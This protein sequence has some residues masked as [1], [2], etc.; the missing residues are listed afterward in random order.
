MASVFLLDN[1]EIRVRHA[2]YMNARI[3]LKHPA[4]VSAAYRCRDRNRLFHRLNE[5][6]WRAGY[7]LLAERVQNGP[8]VCSGR[9][10]AAHGLKA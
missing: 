8:N 2:N 10:A 1:C 6:N 5:R 3:H 4:V 9:K 7:R